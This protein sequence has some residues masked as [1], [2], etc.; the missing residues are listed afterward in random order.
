MVISD[1]GGIIQT[2]NDQT[3]RLLGYTHDELVGESIDRLVPAVARSGH[4]ARRATFIAAPSTRVMS[5][6]RELHA[7]HKDGHEIPVSITLGPVQ[8]DHGLWTIAAVRD[9]TERR[10]AE[11]QLRA[12]EDQFR[13]SFDDAS[14]GMTVADLDGRYVQVNDAFCRVARTLPRHASRPLAPCDHAP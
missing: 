9:I 4:A 14:I 5:G 11:E 7:R 12:A 8:T 6:E 3:E 2:V 10:L 1:A 13:R